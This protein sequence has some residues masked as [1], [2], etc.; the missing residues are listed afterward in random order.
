MAEATTA[1]IRAEQLVNKLWRDGKLGADVQKLA[2]ETFPDAEIHTVDE[3]LAPV[4]A[5]FRAQNEAL[6]A[7]LKAMREEREAERKAAKE[8]ADEEQKASFQDQIAKARNAYNLTDEGFD[9]MVERMKATGNYQDPE[10]AAAWVSSKEPPPPPPGPTFGPQALNLFGSQKFD[11]K[12]AL[13]HHDPEAYADAEFAEFARDPD[14]YT[15]ETF[16]GRR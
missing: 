2:K 16:G 13:L 3:T 9:K 5:P 12:R 14:A 10:A 15:A 1:Q 7:E 6:A 8:R 11:E 4:L